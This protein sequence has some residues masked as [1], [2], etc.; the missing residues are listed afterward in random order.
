[1]APHEGLHAATTPQTNCDLNV[2]YYGSRGRDLGYTP[3]K[4]PVGAMG[5]CP[6]LLRCAKYVPGC[7]PPNPLAVPQSTRG[8][9]RGS[10]VLR[11]MRGRCDPEGRVL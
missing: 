9:A 11:P 10:T 7:R 5:T 1:M 6:R 4:A 2:C 8:R 3:Q